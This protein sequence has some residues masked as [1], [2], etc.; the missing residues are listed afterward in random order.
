MSVPG[1]G[2]GEGRRVEAEVDQPLGDVLGGHARR[3]GQRAQVEDAL[4]G[5]AAPRAGVQDGEAA[6]SQPGGQVVGVQDRDLGGPLEALRA[7]ERNVRPRDGQNA[8]GALRRGGNLGAPARR[9]G[10]APGARPLPPAQ[11]PVL[12]RRAGCRTSCAGSGGETSA[13]ELARPG[14]ADQGVQVRP[15]DVPPGRRRRAPGRTPRARA[16]RTRRAS[17]GTSSSARRPPRRAPPAGAQI[18]GVDRAVRGRGHDDDA[19]P[20]Q[21]SRRRVGAVRRRRDE[22][23]PALGLAAGGVVPADRQ[24]PRQLARGSG[25]RLHADRGVSGDL[26]QPPLEL[27]DQPR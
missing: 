10:T 2:E 22:A 27:A 24:Q 8:R 3:G 25:V 12:P 16:P 9:A 7:H 17:T 20:R 23:H 6:P 13:A 4:V 14:Q 26:G 21:H 19:H 1:D 11:R 5:D 15:V 18:V